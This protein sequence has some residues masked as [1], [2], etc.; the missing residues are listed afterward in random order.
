MRYRNLLHSLT[1]LLVLL[2]PYMA[3]AQTFTAVTTGPVVSDSGYTRSGSWGD[4][5]NDGDLDLFVAN[6]GWLAEHDPQNILYTNNGDGTF[7]PVTTGP[8]STDE[9]RSRGAAWG[10]IDNDGDLDLF[11]ANTYENNFLY[12]NNGD[13]SYTKVTSGPVVT[14]G[15]TSVGGAWG[16]YDNDGYLDLFVANCCGGNDN[17]LYTNN[18]DG[19]FTQ[20]TSGPLVTGTYGASDIHG[21]TWGDYD[22]DGDLDIFIA[23]W[24]GNYLYDNNGDGTFS[25]ASAGP[26]NTDGG[27]SYGGTWG[28]YDNDGDLDLFVAN[29]SGDNFLYNNNGDGSFTRITTGLIVTGGYFALGSAWEDA[30]NDG[31]LDLFMPTNGSNQLHMNNGDGTFTQTFLGGGLSMP[32]SV[33]GDYDNDG[34]QD[35]FVPN[36]QNENDYLYNNGS[37]N[38]WIDLKLVGTQSNVSAIGAKVRIKALIGGSEVW[39]LDEVSGNSNGYSQNSL[40]AGFGLGDATIIDSIKIEW[41]S[42]ITWDT[43]NVAINQF[44]TINEPDEPPAAPANL[45]ATAGNQQIDL[46]W[47]PN[48]E[49]DFSKYY[50]YGGATTTPTIKVDSSTASDLNDTTATITGLDYGTSYYYRLTAVDDVGNESGYSNE[51]SATTFTA[52]Q[53]DSL[54]LVA[55]YNSTDGANWTDN[56]GWLSADTALTDWYGVSVSGGRVTY[57]NLYQ[58]NLVGPLPPEIGNLTA[59]EGIYL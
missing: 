13:G 50:V 57:L 52:L 46:H 42:G 49:A 3:L 47:N 26:V 35:L 45:T 23:N 14:D 44:L 24:G 32:G 58:N 9:G 10:D 18:G 1:L 37:S 20:E 40:N 25:S 29:Y 27:Y 59:L 11:V 41:P 6:D 56:S 43:T 21:A 51:V 38:R 34:D 15:A 22:S 2:I 33:W 5:D 12:T 54:A 28:D 8:L 17:F 36:G 39:Q 7:A 4:Y 19:T 16:D 53:Q 30:D 31:D 55:L 48:S